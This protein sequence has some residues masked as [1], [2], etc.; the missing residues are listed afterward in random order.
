MNTVVVAFF[1][2]AISIAVYFALS[3]L[4]AVKSPSLVGAEEYRL[5]TSQM[6]MNSELLRRVWQ[7]TENTASGASL[8]FFVWPTLKDKTTRTG[9]EYATAI[10]IADSVKFKILTSASAT[11]TSSAPAVLEVNATGLSAPVQL[12]IPDIPLQRWSAIAV[13]KQGRRFKVYVNN[14]LTAATMLDTM[15]AYNTSG[16]LMIGDSRLAGKIA[17]LSIIDY[18]MSTDGVADYFRG[19]SN[20]SFKPYLSSESS[21]AI[22]SLSGFQIKCPGG[23]CGGTAPLANPLEKWSSPYG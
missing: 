19:L 21:L 3:A 15:P 16:S 17:Y 18:P 23:I 6:V 10:N 9:N 13:V 22:P 2:L 7:G 11:R 4:F 14:K 20:S 1:I 12:E 5:E 8:L